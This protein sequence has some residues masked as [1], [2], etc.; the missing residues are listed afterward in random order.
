MTN[1]TGNAL[2]IT[3]EVPGLIVYDHLD[4]DVT[5][6]KLAGLYL[7]D[8][9]LDLD[10]LF[11]RDN[12]FLDEI[13]HSAV[14]DHPVDAGLYL[15]LIARIC[16]HHIPFSGSVTSEALAFERGVSCLYRLLCLNGFADICAFDIL[17]II[18][19][20][21]HVLTPWVRTVL[22]RGCP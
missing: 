11:S 12:D 18:D 13:L 16:M 7:L 3:Y 6:E 20:I 14:L 2:S 19:L 22:F 1:E 9:V 5:R 15:V 10:P 21:C 4:D 8:S 17:D